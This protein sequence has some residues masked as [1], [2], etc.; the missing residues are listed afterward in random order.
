VGI[1]NGASTTRFVVDPNAAL[2]Q[3]LTRIK[4]DNSKTYY[5][6]GAGL[7]Y[8][9]NETSGGVETGTATYHYDY[10]GSTVA[11]T[12]IPLEPEFRS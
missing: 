9:V 12:T 11:I 4:P 5:V 7:L 2:S 1:T 6:Y 10:R 8:D 3:V